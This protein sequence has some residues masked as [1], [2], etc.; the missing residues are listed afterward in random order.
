[1]GPTATVL[2]AAQAR[3]SRQSGMSGTGAPGIPDI[4]DMS[5][6]VGRLMLVPVALAKGLE[7]A[8]V[9]V[10]GMEDGT[11]PHRNAV[12]EKRMEEERRLMYVAMTRARFRLTLSCCRKRRRYG[13]EESLQPSPF[14]GEIDG[15]HLSWVDRDTDSEDAKAEAASHM[16]A[17]RAM[18]TRLGS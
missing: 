16:D 2:L 11:F 8:H 7:F 9:Y 5:E 17:M 12:E 1:M 10:V 13:A 15:E 14:L 4:S 6:S 18:L 3:H